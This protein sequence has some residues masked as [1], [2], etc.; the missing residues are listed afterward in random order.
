MNGLVPLV[1]RTSIPPGSPWALRRR[2]QVH[3]DIFA[4]T[5]YHFEWGKSISTAQ[6]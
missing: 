4:E 6:L 2:L 5:L 1:G 3:K